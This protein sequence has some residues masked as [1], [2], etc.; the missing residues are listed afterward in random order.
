MA[1]H[2]VIRAT[3][4]TDVLVVDGAVL[5]GVVWKEA[6]PDGTDLEIRVGDADDPLAGMVRMRGGMEI[7]DLVVGRGSW[8]RAM[9][10]RATPVTT[11]DGELPVVDRA[12]L[13]L[14]KLYAGGP[15]DRLDIQLLM[16]RAEG[17]VAASVEERI[18]SAPNIVQKNWTALRATKG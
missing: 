17:A 6:L 12:D 13:I 7:V 4:D 14:L 9:L 15:Q 8:Q 11:P 1:A 5:D 18:S 2:G 3:L 16:D 10:S